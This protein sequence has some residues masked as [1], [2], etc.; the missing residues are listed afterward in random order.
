MWIRGLRPAV[1]LA[2]LALCGCGQ[3]GTPG[4]ET[5]VDTDTRLGT[6]V[7]AN[8]G[9]V[10]DLGEWLKL[11]RPELAR[12]V[13]EWERKVAAR[14]QE[15]REQPDTVGLLPKLRP[16]LVVPVFRKATF[17]EGA[18]LSLP[19]YVKPGARD[20]EVALHLAR[21]GDHE[22][23]RLL[24]DPGV[25][26]EVE[27]LRG[28]RNYPVEWARLVGLVLHYWELELAGGKAE[29]ATG[30][31]VLHQQLRS[32]LDEKAAEGPLGSALLP[33][34]RRALAEAAAAFRG[35]SE[36]KPVL[37]DDI[38][39]ALKGWGDVPALAPGVRPG[40]K[41][42]DVARLFRAGRRGSV[43][44]AADPAGVQRA[45]DLLRL[46]VP[47]EGVQA[48]CAFLDAKDR[49][50]DLQV[51]Y[52]PKVDLYPEPVHLAY[53][54]A[55]SG[56]K[57]GEVGHAPG[58]LRQTY[59]G[60]GLVFEASRVTRG[61]AL[62]GL[63]RVSDGTPPGATFRVDPRD[64]GLV[65][66]DRSFEANRLALAPGQAGP[67][68]VVRRR[69]AVGEVAK[70][71]KVPAPER[72]RVVR[73]P[74]QDLVAAVTL[75]WPAEVNPTALEQLLPHLWAAFG[76][77]RV[78]GVEESAGEGLVLA[79]EDGRTRARL[80]LPFSEDDAP[81]LVIEDARG[82]AGLKGR[83]EAA[84]RF[85]LKERRE[86]LAAGTPWLRLRRAVTLVNE[87]ASPGLRLGATRHDVLAA[88]P[89]SSTV[90]QGTLP[91]G[92]T[93]LLLANPP[94]AAAYWGRQVFVRF[95]QDGR[96]AEVR[97]RYEDGPAGNSTRALRE[98][99]E[100]DLGGKPEE[101]PADWQGLWDDLPGRRKAVKLRWQDDRTIWTY[102]RDPGAAE[103]VLR[104][105]PADEPDGVDLPPL[106]FCARGVRGCQ[107][108]DRRADVIKAL[109]KSEAL[110]DGAEVF[111]LPAR[112]P[113]IGVRVWYEGGKVARVVADHRGKPGASAR[114]AESAL[115]GVWG[116]DFDRLGYVRLRL[117]R[118]GSF[119]GAY[120]WHDDR[121]RVQTYAQDTTEG[122]RL[123]TEWRPWP[124]RATPGGGK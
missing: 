65:H 69:Q 103:V 55:D 11:P 53:H 122:P 70:A 44:R 31:V 87:P 100:R 59:R 86:R 121:T 38:E 51:L 32:V 108:G 77:P 93:F 94:E 9:E 84:R 19:P 75:R 33:R 27:A 110:P 105:R 101:V 76:S 17:S 28:G 74:A 10:I 54:L 82:P 25:R 37:A 96:V 123:F 115:Q 47:G 112:S 120:F 117:E 1:V 57:G 80:R 5:P 85:D 2:G 8:P 102:Q 88:L 56:C 98:T 14:E 72:V 118:Q 52:A 48:V 41:A 64:L 29:G 34:G 99:L 89:A 111:Y 39:S 30:L 4:V 43:V 107:L 22:G 49:L 45:L 78:D 116:R 61:N 40:A 18:G 12:L 16:P 13:D 50:A 68:L 113:Y 24:A 95:G 97:V 6:K 35:G 20:A 21:H 67:S 60:A 92:V 83:A 36:N 3:S 109:G 71:L 124:V 119:L 62:S 90:R 91:G 42:A 73:E 114:D 79:W 46:P 106:A 66:L 26:A 63:V 23:A 15:A 104:D 7:E 58:L 81:G